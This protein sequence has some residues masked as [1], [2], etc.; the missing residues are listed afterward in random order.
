M[1]RNSTPEHGDSRAVDEATRRYDACMLQQGMPAAWVNWDGVTPVGTDASPGDPG[2]FTMDTYEAASA[3]CDPVLLQH[4][5]HELTEDQIGH[6]QRVWKPIVRALRTV[7]V[8]ADIV[9]AMRMGLAAK[10]NSEGERIMEEALGPDAE[11][12]LTE[13]SPLIESVTK[14]FLGPS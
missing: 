2:Y 11:A 14:R 6:Q 12:R 10:S 13:A 9:E 7:G 4:R 1:N 8:P 5:G 3:V